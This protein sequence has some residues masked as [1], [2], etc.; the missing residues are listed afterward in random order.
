MFMLQDCG[1]RRGDAMLEVRQKEVRRGVPQRLVRDSEGGCKTASTEMDA[2][3]KDG[4]RQIPAK[5]TRRLGSYVYRGRW[6]WRS[7]SS[8]F[9]L[10][11]LNQRCESA[12][13]A[14]EVATLQ[15]PRQGLQL[16]T[17]PDYALQ[18]GQCLTRPLQIIRG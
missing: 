18:S 3:R 17:L 4:G 7:A 2:D 16:R 12:P 13:R 6:R 8:N 9:T 11:I 5:S 10:D 14:G 1:S 15:C